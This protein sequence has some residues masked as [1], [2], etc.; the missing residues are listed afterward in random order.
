MAGIRIR[1][2]GRPEA[3]YLV[4]RLV[5]AAARELKIDLIVIATHGYT[6]VK[7]LVLGSTAERVVRHAGC[8]VLVVRE[9]ERELLVGV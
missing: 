5:D 1:G 2:A 6:G 7:H 9:K 8:P 3:N 4:E